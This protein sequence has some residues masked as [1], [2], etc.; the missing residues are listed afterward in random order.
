M[1]AVNAMLRNQDGIVSDSSEQDYGEDREPW[2]GIAEDTA[3]DHEDEYIDDDRFTTV[4]VEAVNVSR[5]G[6]HKVR[7]E[8]DDS[9][10]SSA[11]R[12][13]KGTTSESVAKESAEAQKAK[14]KWTKE[15]PSGSKKRKKKFRYESK[16]ERKATRFKE[17][18]GNKV[19]AKAR[20]G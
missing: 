17:K 18:V 4:T 10:A 11:G 14:R 3:Q 13:S 8:N 6:L 9:D 12:P 20:K 16:A 2:N 19:K 5:D 1:E 15:A 7:Q